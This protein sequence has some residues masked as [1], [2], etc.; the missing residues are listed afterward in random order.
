[1][2][3]EPLKLVDAPVPTGSRAPTCRLTEGEFK[4]LVGEVTDEPDCEQALLA[5][6]T[7]L[8]A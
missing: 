4:Q 3:G 7:V 5:I 6:E 1:M 8:E 2:K